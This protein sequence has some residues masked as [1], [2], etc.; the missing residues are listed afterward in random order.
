[1]GSLPISATPVP[2]GP[3]VATTGH[4]FRLSVA[5]MGGEFLLGLRREVEMIRAGQT[6]S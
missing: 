6:R 2:R 4:P 3:A 1:M 5:R